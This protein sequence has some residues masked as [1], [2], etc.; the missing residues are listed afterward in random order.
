MLGEIAG[1]GFF[2]T[3]SVLRDNEVTRVMGRNSRLAIQC[4]GMGGFSPLAARAGW[5]V[6]RVLDGPTIHSLLLE[7]TGPEEV[8]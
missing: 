4:R 8:A 3:G 7:A 1:A 2:L 6:R 5:E